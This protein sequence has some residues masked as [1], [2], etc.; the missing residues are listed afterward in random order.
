MSDKLADIKDLDDMIRNLKGLGK[1]NTVR[2]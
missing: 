1:V 2:W